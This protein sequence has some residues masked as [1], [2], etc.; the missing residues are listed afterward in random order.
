MFYIS[1]ACRTS[2]SLLVL[3]GANGAAKNKKREWV[4]MTNAIEVTPQVGLEPTTSRLTVGCSTTELLRIA[5]GSIEP[6]GLR[7]ANGS[8]SIYKSI[9]GSW[10]KRKAHQCVVLHF[11]ILASHSLREAPRLSLREATRSAMCVHSRRELLDH[12]VI[13]SHRRW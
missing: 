13:N 3:R 10:A 11:V 8:R 5:K 1:C 9:P 12:I 7:F 6:K 2:S 4:D